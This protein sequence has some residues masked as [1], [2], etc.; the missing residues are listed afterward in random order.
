MALLILLST[1]VAIVLWLLILIPEGAAE[2]N[3][4]WGHRYLLPFLLLCRDN[5][6][7]QLYWTQE[8]QHFPL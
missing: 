3:H 4:I 6:L 8:N 1:F 5:C 7:F 2:T